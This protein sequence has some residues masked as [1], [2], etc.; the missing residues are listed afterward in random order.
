V[1]RNQLGRDVRIVCGRSQSSRSGLTDCFHDAV[2]KHGYEHPVQA[3]FFEQDGMLVA[4]RLCDDDMR[5]IRVPNGGILHLRGFDGEAVARVYHSE[6]DR[7]ETPKFLDGRLV[8]TSRDQSL[9]GAPSTAS[10]SAFVAPGSSQGQS[11]AC[12][13]ADVT[14]TSSS[15]SAPAA[16]C[17]AAAISSTSGCP[18]IQEAS[19]PR[20]RGGHVPHECICPISHEI[21]TDPVLAADGFTYERCCIEEWW[22]RR[23]PRSPMTGK[24]LASTAL[25]ANLAIR[26]LCEERCGPDIQGVTAGGTHDIAGANG[27]YESHL[28]ALCEMFAH[29]GEAEV[30]SVCEGLVAA[31]VED[32]DACVRQL[33]QASGTLS[34]G[35]PA[36]GVCLAPVCCAGPCDDDT[37]PSSS[38][39]F[40]CHQF[41]PAKPSTLEPQQTL[42]MQ[43]Y[44]LSGTSMTTTSIHGGFAAAGERATSDG[45][46]SRRHGS[47]RAPSPVFPGPAPGVQEHR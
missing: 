10:G 14:S 7:W 15:L 44:G 38:V 23:G 16:S 35:S 46:P 18:G 3:P 1:V 36:A 42:R 8:F 41:V 20:A 22:R 9:A 5:M 29:L 30:R 28:P 11:S 33:L 37:A 31:G 43:L 4:A 21:F 27:F 47:S 2:A 19:P 34:E 17:D 25:T 24:E 13:L 45:R 32:M 12:I 6:R 39:S 26:A 40:K